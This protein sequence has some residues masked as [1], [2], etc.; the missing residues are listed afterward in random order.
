MMTDEAAK[1]YAGQIIAYSNDVEVAVKR[2][3]LRGCKDTEI[4][5]ERP[6][7]SA[8]VNPLTPATGSCKVFASNGGG[9]I[10]KTPPT[11]VLDTSKNHL[12]GFS[13]GHYYYSGRVRVIGSGK[14][15]AN[16]ECAELVLELP[17]LTL[18]ACEAINEIL[19]VDTSDISKTAVGTYM[20]ASVNNHGYQ[21]AYRFTGTYSFSD[22]GATSSYGDDEDF[23]RGLGA[24]C[25]HRHGSEMSE[26]PY[27]Y[28]KVLLPR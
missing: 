22:A 1:A 19:G 2:L 15:C 12:N 14:D 5:F 17:H 6:D 25:V 8:Y 20:S 24:A 7:G 27:V 10:W 3:R 11:Q 21:N 28:F 9:I 4:S 23:L 13:Y 16:M 26:N 18:A